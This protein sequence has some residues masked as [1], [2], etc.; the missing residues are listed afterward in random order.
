MSHSHGAYKLHPTYFGINHV[1]VWLENMHFVQLCK[2]YELPIDTFVKTYDYDFQNREYG[3]CYVWTLH[4]MNE[5]TMYVLLWCY[6]VLY[7]CVTCYIP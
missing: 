4:A 1:I 2:G 6:R 3:L 5:M 7:I